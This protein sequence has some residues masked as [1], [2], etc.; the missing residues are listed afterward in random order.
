MTTTVKHR[1]LRLDILAADETQTAEHRVFCQLR[2]QATRV[3]ACCQCVHCDA[4]TDGAAPVVECAIP[5]LPLAPSDD[6]TG[7][8]VEVATLLRRGTMVIEETVGL[9]RARDLLRD[10]DRRS[11]PIVSADGVLVGIVHEAGFVGRRGLP[12]T[13]GEEMSTPISVDERTPVRDALKVLAA[14]H[15][16]EVPVVTARGVPIGVFGD[17]EGLRWIARARAA[18]VARRDRDRDR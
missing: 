8:R 11:V 18:A 6:P 12:G 7:E 15:L 1:I 9:A 3:D 5:I 10:Q 4:I 13:V 16:R 17:L 2:G 14:S